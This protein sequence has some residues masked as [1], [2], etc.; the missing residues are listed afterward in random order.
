MANCFLTPC[1]WYTP[2]MASR[3]LIQ[4]SLASFRRMRWHVRLTLW[5]FAALA[6]LVVA[7]FAKGADLSLALFFTL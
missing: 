3:P 1:G 4:R 5:S 7:A 2:S 6:G